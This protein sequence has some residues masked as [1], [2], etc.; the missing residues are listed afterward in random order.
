MNPDE[1]TEKNNYENTLQK[2]LKR[3][4]TLVNSIDG[5]VWEADVN[6]NFT[7]VSKKAERLLG[8]SLNEWYQPN[9]WADHLHPEDKVRVVKLCKDQC[10]LLLPHD[11]FL[12]QFLISLYV[13]LLT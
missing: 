10:D 7:F 9:F 12:L 11:L 13:C 6:I 8:Y 1:I 5:I 2:S 3:Y 4:E